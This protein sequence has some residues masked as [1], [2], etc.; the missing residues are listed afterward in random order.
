MTIS[1]LAELDPFCRNTPADSASAQPGRVEE[2]P[3]NVFSV[4]VKQKRDGAGATEWNVCRTEL[5]PPFR[6]HRTNGGA[7]LSKLNG[8]EKKVSRTVTLRIPAKHADAMAERSSSGAR[9]I[10]G[11]KQLSPKRWAIKTFSSP[12]G[13]RRDLSLFR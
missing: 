12:I 3:S 13:S 9:F 6:A 7:D 5:R 2:L 1:R 10:G 11:K 4:S 8:N